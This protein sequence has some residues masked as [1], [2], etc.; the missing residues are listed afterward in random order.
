MSARKSE[1][2][3]KMNPEAVQALVREREVHRDLYID[4][5][6]FDLEM[7]YLFASTW[8]F[9]GHESQIPNVGDYYTTTVGNEPVVMVRH[10]DKTI[11]VL[12]NRCPHRGVRYV[13]IP[14]SFSAAPITHGHF[15]PTEK[16]WQFHSKAAMKMPGL[17]PAMPPKG[18]SLSTMCRI[19]AVS[20]SAG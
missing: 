2:H 7:E 16:F 11:K 12:Y 19:I 8:I 10:T 18:W 15:A 14:E 1:N 5:D 6:V 17:I 3:Y 13:G 4:E 9:V 20:F